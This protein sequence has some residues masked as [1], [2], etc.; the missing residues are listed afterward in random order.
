MKRLIAAIL[1]IYVMGISQADAGMV[2]DP[3]AGTGTWL[4]VPNGGFETGDMSS[5]PPQIPPNNAGKGLFVASSEQ[6]W[7]GN[8]SSKADPLTNFTGAGFAHI[9]DP[10]AITVTPG[11]TYVLSAFFYTAGMTHGNLSMDLAD[12]GFNIRINA[13]LD[14]GWHFAWGE[15]T[16][17]LNNVRVRILRDSD[18]RLGEF[19]FID[20]IGITP[21]Q[22]FRAPNVRT[23]AVPEPSSLVL[24]GIGTMGIILVFRRSRQQ[25]AA[26]PEHP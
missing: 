13:T 23:A 26:G 21:L 19:G 15:F 17:T 5:W 9:T 25:T 12:V 6:V 11:E 2:L 7:S 16:P 20:E 8:F 10:T 24:C 4:T 22:D 3:E 14:E 18:V 1:A